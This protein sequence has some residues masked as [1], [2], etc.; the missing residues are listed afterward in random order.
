MAKRR[1]EQKPQNPFAGSKNLHGKIQAVMHDLQSIEKDGAFKVFD[2]AKKQWQERYKFVSHDN[3]I[4]AVSASMRTHGLRFG[5]STVDYMMTP[6]GAVDRSK[7]PVFR[8][9]VKN[10]YTTTCVDTGEA[11]V[12]DWV[13]EGIDSQ[14]KAMPKA[15][16]Q[17]KKTYFISKFLICTGDQ[18]TDADYGHGYEGY[19][20]RESGPARSIPA[21]VQRKGEPEQQAAVNPK[22]KALTMALK[23]AI[24]R[25]EPADEKGSPV[26]A[27]VAKTISSVPG[28]GVFDLSRPG[29]NHWTDDQ[30]E[31]LL[32]FYLSD[33]EEEGDSWES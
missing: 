13:G 18:S 4:A 31:V 27:A 32:N 2:A 33:L 8:A 17:C 5:A 21:P 26:W 29:F 25:S 7:S 6:T 19:Q 15:H 28:C 23:D 14:D 10:R 3:V 11:D 22:R 30:I 9:I 16:T 1:Q 20:G 12:E 24:L